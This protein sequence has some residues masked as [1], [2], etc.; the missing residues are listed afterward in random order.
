LDRALRLVEDTAVR[1]Q[2]LDSLT[3]ISDLA[4]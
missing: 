4:G 3:E 1:K 2:L